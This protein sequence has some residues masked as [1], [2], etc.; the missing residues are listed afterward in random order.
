VYAI[1]AEIYETPIWQPEL[2]GV[3]YSALNFT[4]LDKA[5]GI[6]TYTRQLRV[7]YGDSDAT[8]L[9]ADNLQFPIIIKPGENEIL[10]LSDKKISELDKSLKKFSLASFDPDQWDYAKERRDDKSVSYQMV[11]QPGTS[12]IFLYSGAGLSSGGGY[13]FILDTATGNIC[14]LDLG[15]W[16]DRARWSANGRYLAIERAIG[17]SFPVISSDLVVLDTLTGSLRIVEVVS[18]D[19]KKHHVSDFTW[20]PDNFHMFVFVDI[21]STYDPNNFETLHHKLYF[22]DLT[23]GK[24]IPL[25]PE[26]KSFFAESIPGSNNFV[27][28]LDNSKLLLRCPL[29][30]RPAATDR[31]CLTSVQRADQ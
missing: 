25:F 26:F 28:S 5:K 19:I 17:Y 4:S 31:F 23:T 30:K 13:T 15:G 1:R 27:W 10:Y 9:L 12:L 11:W 6:H 8:Q 20:T 7:S 22:V 3:V 16:A 18:Q 2:N 24:S 21:P 29:I 14:E